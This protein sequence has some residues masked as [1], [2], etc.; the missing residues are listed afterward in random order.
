MNYV[1]IHLVSYF[2]SGPMME[3]GAPYPYSAEIPET[4]FLPRVLPETDAHAGVVVGLGLAVAL[5]ALLQRTAVGF[6]LT[7]IGSNVQAA[8]YAGMAVRRHLVGALVAGGALAGLA[9]TYEVLGLKYRLFHMFSPGYGYD[10]IV[11]TF[12]AGGNAVLVVVAATFLAGLRSGASIMQR[13]VGVETT[14]VEAI[15]GLV[16]LFVAVSLAFR[17]DRTAW[18]RVLRPPATAESGTARADPGGG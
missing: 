11:V 12:L 18:S 6:A 14:I 7:T 1:A 2:V 17:L 8:R 15:E 9:G 13:V 4:L 5:H 3:E 10:G 16:I